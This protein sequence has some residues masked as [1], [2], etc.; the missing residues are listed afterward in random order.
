MDKNII[1][2]T[3]LSLEG[4]ALQSAREKYFDY[5]ADA[6]LDQSKPIECDE[7]AQAEIASDLSE[8]LDDTRDDHTD[9]PDKL[10]E[11]DFAPK[12]TVT[13]GPLCGF[14]VDTSSLPSPPA[15]SHAMVERS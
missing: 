5:I 15:S 12:S 14:L 8:A 4:A 13:E 10:R 7:Q 3:M 9:K 1:K 6:S 2:E 11:V